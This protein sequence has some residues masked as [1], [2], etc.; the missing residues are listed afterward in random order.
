[1]IPSVRNSVK[2]IAKYG[3]TR[4]PSWLA[5]KPELSW[6]T[7]EEALT[8]GWT[9]TQHVSCMKLHTAARQ[10]KQRV[11]HTTGQGR[12]G[13]TRFIFLH[14]CKS[15]T[16]PLRIISHRET[17]GLC[18]V[19]AGEITFKIRFILQLEA[20]NVHFRMKISISHILPYYAMKNGS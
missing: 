2:F 9:Y 8:L 6:P 7:V 10:D 20:S 13:K 11:K 4:F 17:D 15:L 5:R 3:S 19:F 12:L 1:M 18:N 16:S 14:Q